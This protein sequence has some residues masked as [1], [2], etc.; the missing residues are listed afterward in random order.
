MRASGH[1]QLSVIPIFRAPQSSSEYREPGAKGSKNSDCI[2]AEWTI[3]FKERRSL[4]FKSK[5]HF[6]R[7]IVHS[8]SP[9][10]AWKVVYFFNVFNEKGYPCF[11]GQKKKKILILSEYDS[12]SIDSFR[13]Y[14]SIQSIL[15]TGTCKW[16]PSTCHYLL[17]VLKEK[18]MDSARVCRCQKFYYYRKICTFWTPNWLNNLKKKIF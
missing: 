1:R 11:L 15:E 2:S 9:N 18:W 13:L 8:K 6:M 3:P 14:E 12:F 10:A 7:A 16:S 4:H 5:A 17:C